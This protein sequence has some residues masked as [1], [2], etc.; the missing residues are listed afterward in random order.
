MK[1]IMQINPQTCGQAVVAMLSEFSIQ[2]V[3]A[4]MKTD[5]PTSIGMLIEILDKY[6]ISHGE[7]N[8]RISKK[9][10][11]PGEVS[12][13]TAHLPDYTHWVLLYKGVYYDPEFGIIHEKI[14]PHGK[15]TS[16]LNIYL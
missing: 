4:D 5:G 6:G 10:P 3:I 1:L 8:L 12:I 7:K 14:Y 16:F 15:V 11:V 2:K 13:L 9:N